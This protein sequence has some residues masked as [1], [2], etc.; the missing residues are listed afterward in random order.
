MDIKKDHPVYARD[1]VY[2]KRNL[3]SGNL[4]IDTFFLDT[5]TFMHKCKNSILGESQWAWLEDQVS[6]TKSDLI[7][8][9]SSLN[10]F[11]PVSPFLFWIE[12]WHKFKND[13]KRI[14]KLV[15][16]TKRKLSS[17]LGTGTTVIYRLMSVKGEKKNPRIHV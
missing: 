13:K 1:G 11:S 4:S 12:G 2:H 3:T 14:I 6:K 16:S 17:F 15:D 10:I 7:I 5:R 8:I 9:A